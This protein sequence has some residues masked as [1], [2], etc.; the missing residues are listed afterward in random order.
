MTNTVSALEVEKRTLRMEMSVHEICAAD[1]II[2]VRFCG[3]QHVTYRRDGSVLRALRHCD[4]CRLG[5]LYVLKSWSKEV[6]DS[7][8]RKRDGVTVQTGTL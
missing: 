6:D 8:I 1:C 3:S 2:R 5:N 4:V 7:V